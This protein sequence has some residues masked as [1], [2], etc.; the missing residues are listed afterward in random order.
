MLVDMLLSRVLRGTLPVL[1]LWPM[2]SSLVMLSSAPMSGRV[3][4]RISTSWPA[5]PMRSTQRRT[6]SA[7]SCVAICSKSPAR[8]AVEPG[9][10][11]TYGSLSSVAV[12]HQLIASKP[13]PAQRPGQG[14]GGQQLLQLAPLAGSGGPQGLGQQQHKGQPQQHQARGAGE[15]H[16]RQP[17]PRQQ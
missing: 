3:W 2:L 15:K 14:R 8:R 1:L 13:G 5:L 6:S 4:S 7:R 10:G 16:R 11:S 12:R 17:R 9:A